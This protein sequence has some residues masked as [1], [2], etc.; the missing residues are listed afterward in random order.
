MKLHRNSAYEGKNHSKKGNRDG[1]PP[2]LS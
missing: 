2:L 1:S